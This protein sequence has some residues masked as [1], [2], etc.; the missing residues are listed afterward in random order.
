MRIT[1][2]KDDPVQSSP[3]DFQSYLEDFDEYPFEN[4]DLF[5]EEDYQSSL[6]SNFD[7]GEDVT[8][9]KQD[10]CD[11]LVQLPLIAL[12]CYVTKDVVGKHVSCSKFSLGKKISL[13]FKGRLNA[14]RSLLSQSF[15]FPLR[16]C[17]F[18]PKFLLIHS[19][20]PG[21]DDIQGSQPLDSLRHPF[22]SLTS[23]DIF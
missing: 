22:E 3:D 23:H 19:H 6:C 13:E 21:S 14:L 16:S 8:F 5:Y 4:L 18:S 1:E 12:P 7:K 20:A 9:L 17:Q 11:K 2:P 10:T 15:S